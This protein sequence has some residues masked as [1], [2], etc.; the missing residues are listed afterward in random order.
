MPVLVIAVEARDRSNRARARLGRFVSTLGA[1]R[2]THVDGGLLRI[3]LPH[4]L[5][6]EAFAGIPVTHDTNA[7]AAT[8]SWDWAT[9]ARVARR[10]GFG[11]S[12]GAAY[13]QRRDAGQLASEEVGFDAGLAIGTRADV[14][15]RVAYS[16]ASPGLA[17]VMVSTSLRDDETRTEVYAIHREAS[18]LLP[19]TSVFSVIGDVPSQRA[20]TLVTWKAAP[21]LDVIFDL[22]GR[23]VDQDVGVELATRARLRLDARG[24][25]VV[26]GELRRSGVGVDAWIGGRAN[27]RL[28]VSDSFTLSGELE[29]VRPDDGRGR[30]ELWP[31]GLIA[32]SWQR[33]DWHAALAT[34][35]TSSMEYRYRVDVIAQ[36]SRRWSAL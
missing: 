25:S 34:E 17:E 16:L 9:G 12:I 4:S 11:G 26:A 13:A 18:R 3:R 7:I 6:V 29:L 36:L 1:L 33:G 28:R 5:D 14:A 2:P 24:R 8:R 31:W 21:R 15:G 30:G 20:G 23:H 32:A 22:G 19:A 35:A 27:A 10:F